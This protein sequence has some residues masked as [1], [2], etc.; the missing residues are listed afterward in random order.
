M[1]ASLSGE[2]RTL[3]VTLGV[4]S[5]NGDRV[6]K[7]AV[8]EAAIAQQKVI[9][10]QELQAQHETE[11]RAHQEAQLKAQQDAELKA[12]ANQR[13]VTQDRAKRKKEEPRANLLEESQEGKTP[14]S[15]QQPAP[16][17]P[18]VPLQPAVAPAA[19]H[20]ARARLP[21]GSKT[22]VSLN[23]ASSANWP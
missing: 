19:Q 21:D 12:H 23:Q 20:S 3:Q 17:K 10:Q 22:H 9:V 7:A 13:Q 6:D 18:S 15:A 14:S 11:L 1:L 4:M 8:K 5:Q 16:V 2:L